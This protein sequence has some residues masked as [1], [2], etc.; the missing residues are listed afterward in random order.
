MG[1]MGL[2]EFFAL[3]LFASLASATQVTV[4]S[5][6][7]AVFLSSDYN[8]VEDAGTISAG[9]P[10]VFEVEASASAPGEPLSRWTSLSAELAFLPTGWKQNSFSA[11][12]DKLF[13]SLNSSPLASGLLLLKLRA[14]NDNESQVIAFKVRVNPVSSLVV[15]PQQEKRESDNGLLYWLAGGAAV[16]ALLV[17]TVF[18]ARR[19][20]RS[21]FERER[22]KHRKQQQSIFELMKTGEEKPLIKTEKKSLFSFLEKREPRFETLEKLERKARESRAPP[23]QV[24]KL[25]TPAADYKSEST[26]QLLREVEQA[27]QEL[28][29]KREWKI[30][31]EKEGGRK[32]RG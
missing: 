9:E 26:R 25:E 19:R 4:V 21:Y 32:G 29:P 16:A 13:L 28:K 3:L 15:S 12:D 30:G 23:T 31:E 1:K 20:K 10:I 14:S 11:S 8:H 6:V 17:L 22:L 7:S 5:P 18:Y 2:K 24:P 27:L